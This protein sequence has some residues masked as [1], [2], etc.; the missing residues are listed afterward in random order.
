[1]DID[2]DKTVTIRKLS[3]GEEQA[4]MSSAMSFEMEMA[5]RKGQAAPPAKGKLD[6]FRMK[7]EELLMAIVSWAGPGFDGRPVN[8]DNVD[9]LPPEII[10]IIQTAVDKINGGLSDDEKKALA[11]S[12]NTL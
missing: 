10:D 7:R 5:T 8:K 3:Y 2:A 6:P 11:L 4:A 9:A 1:V 12:M